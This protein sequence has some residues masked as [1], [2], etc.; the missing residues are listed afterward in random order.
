MTIIE[1]HDHSRPVDY[2]ELGNDAATSYGGKDLKFQNDKP[3]PVIINST[4]EDGTVSI[5]I[6]AM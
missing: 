4:V 3:F 6:S 1:R 2:V 5:S